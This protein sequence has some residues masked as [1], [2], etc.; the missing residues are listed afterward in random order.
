MNSLTYLSRQFDGL[1]SSRT[2][3]NTPTPGF[4]LYRPRPSSSPAD[5]LATNHRTT[6]HTAWSLRSLV[7]P[8]P[9]LRRSLS[10]PSR[11]PVLRRRPSIR[12][13]IRAKPQSTSQTLLRRL[14]FVRLLELV[15]HALCTAAASLR[16]DDVWHGRRLTPRGLRIRRRSAGSGQE[17]SVDEREGMAMLSPAHQVV[18][19]HAPSLPEAVATTA[20]LAHPSTPA[21]NPSLVSRRISTDPPAPVPACRSHLGRHHFIYPKTLVLDLDETLIHSTSRPLP[22]AGIQGLFGARRAASH[23]VEVVLG[24]RSALYH[25]YKRPFVGFFLAKGVG[26]V[27]ACDFHGL[28]ADSAINWL[29]ARQGILRRRFLRKLLGQMNHKGRTPP[30][31]RN[32][33]DLDRFQSQICQRTKGKVR[34]DPSSNVNMEL[35]PL[36]ANSNLGPPIPLSSTSS[37]QLLSPGQFSRP[38][39]PLFGLGEKGDIKLWVRYPRG[40]VGRWLHTKQP[41]DTIEIRDISLQ[42]SGG[43]GFLPFHQLLFHHLLHGDVTARTR[44]TLLHAS[45]S[46]AE[47]P[48][49]TLLQPLIDFAVAHHEYLRLKLNNNVAKHLKVGRVDRFSIA[50]ALGISDG[51]RSWFSW[52]RNLWTRDQP[53]VGDSDIRRTN[54]LVLVCG[55]ERMVAAIA[56]PYGKNYS[57]GRSAELG[58]TAGQVWKV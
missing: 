20:V 43:T 4:A 38:Y 7:A 44:F 10:S 21:A 49:L 34:T 16:V 41:G 29:D 39:I 26:P 51:A 53:N 11:V 37:H 50:H 30:T 32:D 52:F 25:V 9:P 19:E 36:S 14:L 12:S 54:V 28:D 2:P 40:E 1:A 55:P 6:E 31:H 3:P 47:L 17:P 22:A 48:P 35:G 24:G 13:T 58:F 18:P 27:Y 42:I 33:F 23:T 56:G 5:D 15:W 46:P 45:R 57:R 8:P